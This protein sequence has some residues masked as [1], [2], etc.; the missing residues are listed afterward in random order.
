MAKRRVRKNKQ[1]GMLKKHGKKP[2]SVE[3]K[4]ERKKEREEQ[5]VR[6][7]ADLKKKSLKK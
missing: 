3:R 4:A 2:M 5:K 7:L 1:C 6:T